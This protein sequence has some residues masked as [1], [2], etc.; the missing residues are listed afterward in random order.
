M[1]VPLIFHFNTYTKV[2][3]SIVAAK[4]EGITIDF[5]VYA[6]SG[7]KTII[8]YANSVTGILRL[9]SFI[10]CSEVRRTLLKSDN[11]CGLTR[12]EALRVEAVAHTPQE[13]R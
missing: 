10:G 8:N 4:H 7:I 6:V 13:I 2:V 11:R 12:G 3:Y 5:T 1:I 9:H